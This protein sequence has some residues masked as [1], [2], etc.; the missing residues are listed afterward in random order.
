MFSGLPGNRENLPGTFSGS[1]RKGKNNR[2]MILS[3]RLFFQFILLF[4]LYIIGYK[5]IITRSQTDTPYSFKIY[6]KNV[7][8]QPLTF[9]EHPMNSYAYRFF[10]KTSSRTGQKTYG[11]GDLPGSRFFIYPLKIKIL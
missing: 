9:H 11:T 10:L 7:S 8:L 5:M 1:P 4:L 3:K 6:K 2:F